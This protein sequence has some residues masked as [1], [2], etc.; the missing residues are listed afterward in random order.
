L[1]RA[2]IEVSRVSQLNDPAYA[3]STELRRSRAKL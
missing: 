1:E 2:L 3:P